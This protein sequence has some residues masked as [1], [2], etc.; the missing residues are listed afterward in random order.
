M[1]LVVGGSGDLG[2]RVV[3]RLREGGAQVRCLVRPGTD[4]SP[5]RELGAE[6][7][8]GDLTDPDS[9]VAA[10]Q[11]AQTVVASATAIGRVLAGARRPSIHEVDEVGM[12]SLVDAAERAGV[13]RFVYVSYAGVDSALGTPLERAKASTERRLARSTLRRVVVRPDAFQEVHLAPLGRFDIRSGRVAV[14]GKGDT[15][16][17]WVATEDVAALV[18]AVATEADPPDIVTFGGPEA[19][20]RNEAI[21]IA[22]QASGRTFKV[23][24]MPREVARAGMR[25]LARP[26]PAMATIFGTGLMLDLLPLTWDDAPLRDRGIT[27]RAASEWI[28]E[29]AQHLQ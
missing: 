6:L 15:E 27:P 10:C 26:S 16:R 22:E 3:R 9:L 2:R 8:A 7:V 18:A 5:L 21:R 17:R 24:R 13:E 28:L 4:G 19:I 25:I 12:A 29:Q 23:Q 11:G 14:F 20:S 1:I